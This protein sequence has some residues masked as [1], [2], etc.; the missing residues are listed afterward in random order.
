[1]HAPSILKTARGR[2]IAF[3]RTDG[4]GPGVVFLGGFQSDM[5]GTKATTLEEWARVRGRAFVRF[6]YSG[7][8]QSSG[9]FAEG[10]IGDWAEDAMAVV[11][12]TEGP[13][14][15]VGSSMGGW[16]S[17]LV[18]RAMPGKVCGFVGVAAAPDFV[19]DAF[20]AGFDAAQRRQ[21]EEEGQVWLPSDYGDPFPVTKR[22][23]EDARE[24]L[25]LRAPLEMPFPVRLLQ[26]G[27]DEVVP[28]EA[29]LRLFDHIAGPDVR[30]TIVKG[31][32]H[33]FSE[34]ENLAQIIAAIEE[35]AG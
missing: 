23:V 7:H 13:Q 9:A 19:E 4:E 30:L 20:W 3:H 33:R 14:V 31:T 34:P 16:I 21:L 24:R 18:I 15:L 35:V 8:G 6:D 10:C 2:E 29:A 11:A 22:L 25:V 12:A 32:D 1:M 28:R 26:G 5:T 17:S 27:A